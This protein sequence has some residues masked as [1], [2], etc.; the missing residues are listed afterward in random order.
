MN[1]TIRKL[2]FATNTGAVE[3]FND[4]YSVHVVDGSTPVGTF[5]VEL[6]NPSELT[7]VVFDIVTMPSDPGIRVFASADG[8][9]QVEASVVEAVVAHLKTRCRASAFSTIS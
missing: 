1:A 7:L 3:Q 6:F 5:Q 2:L 9:T 4:M 8:V